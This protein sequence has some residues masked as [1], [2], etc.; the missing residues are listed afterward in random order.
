MKLWLPIDAYFGI[1]LSRERLLAVPTVIDHWL[2]ADHVAYR[3]EFR[4]LLYV[5][6]IVDLKR[7]SLSLRRQRHKA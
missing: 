1:G 4:V 2:S 6:V 3:F 7:C 5:C